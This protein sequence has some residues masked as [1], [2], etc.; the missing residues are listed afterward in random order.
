MIALRPEH[1]IHGRRAANNLFALGLRHTAG[2]GD[3]D[4]AIFRCGALF[5]AAHAAEFGINLFRCFFPDVAGVENNEIGIFRRA[6]LDITVWRQSVRHPTRIVDVHLAAERFDV[7]F[8]GSCHA[9]TAKP[10]PLPQIT[11]F[12]P[13]DYPRRP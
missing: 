5:Q 1:Q 11:K 7:K 13:A 9:A 6:G 4:M 8:A 2:D 3:H 12:A 10:N